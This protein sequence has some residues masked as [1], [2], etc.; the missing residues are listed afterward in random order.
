MRVSAGRCF[1]RLGVRLVRRSAGGC[2]RTSEDPTSQK[3]AGCGPLLARVL[4]AGQC[5]A[6]A[7]A[8]GARHS[9]L[10]PSLYL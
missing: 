1:V 10:P 9:A 2:N 7:C 4:A 6:N 8:Q 5:M 3:R